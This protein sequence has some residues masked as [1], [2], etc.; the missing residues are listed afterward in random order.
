MRHM[1][2]H[3]WLQ[4][5]LG[6]WPPAAARARAVHAQ[7]PAAAC[8]RG[9]RSGASGALHASTSAGARSTMHASLACR[10]HACLP[11]T[12]RH[13][14]WCVPPATSCCSAC[15]AAVAERHAPRSAYAAGR[16]AASVATAWSRATGGGS[17]KLEPHQSSLQGAPRTR[18]QAV[19]PS[20]RA[21]HMCPRSGF[22]GSR[23]NAPCA[24]AGEHRIWQTCC[25]QVLPS[26]ALPRSSRGAGEGP[27][28]CRS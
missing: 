17:C 28:Y 19:G 9:T 1:Q 21:R 7:A 16:S 2:C 13:L 15:V 23:A 12:A 3:V 25:A 4:Q 8:V 10:A 20:A 24:L 11:G 26:A 5:R 6:A 14:P 18:W 27:A 22:A